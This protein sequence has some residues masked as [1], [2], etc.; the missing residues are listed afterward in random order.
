[1]LSH[2]LSSVN[3]VESS[4]KHFLL[5]RNHQVEFLPRLQRKLAGLIFLRSKITVCCIWKIA[6]S[7]LWMQKSNQMM[8]NLYWHAYQ[9]LWKSVF[10][11]E[12]ELAFIDKSLTGPKLKQRNLRKPGIFLKSKIGSRIGVE[13]YNS[14][15]CVAYKDTS[16]ECLHE[17][18]ENLN[19]VELEKRY[20]SKFLPTIVKIHD[21][22]KCLIL[23][24]IVGRN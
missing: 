7:S 19:E 12:K 2:Q 23:W 1:M 24:K 13:F 6:N 22:I 3:L 20:P 17:Q 15:A 10:A 11:L 5:R 4:L 16:L 21:F 18:I 14:V 9:K 8:A